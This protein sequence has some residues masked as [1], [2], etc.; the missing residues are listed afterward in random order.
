[1]WYLPHSHGV[2]SD[3]VKSYRNPERPV[4]GWLLGRGEP[5]QGHSSDNRPSSLTVGSGC[6]HSTTMFGFP[7]MPP[8]SVIMAVLGPWVSTAS[9]F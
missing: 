3:L 1:M 4:V 5:R 9:R 6:L 2:S 7:H 8:L